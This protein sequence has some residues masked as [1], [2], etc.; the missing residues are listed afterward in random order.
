MQNLDLPELQVGHS[1]LRLQGT[2]N[3]SWLCILNIS[4]ASCCSACHVKSGCWR[5]EELS[6]C[7]H[8][9]PCM[10]S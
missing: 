8:K 2:R 10:L 3:V 7:A 1:T 9:F 6:P 5:D 4:S